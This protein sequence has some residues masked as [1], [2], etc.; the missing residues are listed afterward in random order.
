MIYGNIYVFFLLPWTLLIQRHR[1][2]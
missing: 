2:K 1:W